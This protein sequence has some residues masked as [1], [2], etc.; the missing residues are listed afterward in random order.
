VNDDK[1]LQIIQRVIFG[2]VKDP[3]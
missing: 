3:T 2:I 1:V